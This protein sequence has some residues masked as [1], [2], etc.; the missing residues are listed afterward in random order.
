MSRPV[1]P[2]AAVWPLLPDD[3]L[4][5][6][7]D[8]IAANGLLD[9]ILLDPDGLVIDGRNRLAACEMAGIEPN[10]VILGANQDPVAVIVAHNSHRRHMTTGARAMATALT[11]AAGGLRENGRWKRGV[12]PGSGNKTTSNLMSEA[13]QI[14]DHDEVLAAQVA[15]GEVAID[16]A[17]KQVRDEQAEAERQ[18]RQLATLADKAPDLAAKVEAGDIPLDEA[19]VLD[20][21]RRREEIADEQARVEVRDA[22]CV[23]FFK[24]VAQYGSGSNVDGFRDLYDESVAPHVTADEI[25]GALETLTLIAKQWRN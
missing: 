10:F 23:T 25:D 11:L 19:V 24:F 7:A 18:R 17:Y 15:H 5:A 14:L 12:I 9:P 6:L 4:Q 1:H 2:A 22:N 21:H 20:A 8:D 13:G 3:E 16:A